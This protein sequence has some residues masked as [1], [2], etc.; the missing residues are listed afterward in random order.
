MVY[1]PEE[2]LIFTGDVVS[3]GVH[4]SMTQAET[5]AWL[6]TLNQLRK[7]S[8]DKIVPGRGMTCAKEATHPLS[9]YIRDM[10]AA[11][12]RSFQAGRSKSETSSAVVPEF[13]DAFPYD[14]GQ[15]ERTRLLVKGGSDRIYDEYRAVAKADAARTRKA[16]KKSRPKGRRTT[17]RL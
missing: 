14:E 5:K 4:P 1:L 17:A 3:C 12:R 8:V 11:V 10:R 6:S 9:E 2:S 13:L 7:M 15:R 16:S